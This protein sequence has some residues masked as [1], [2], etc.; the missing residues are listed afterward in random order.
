MVGQSEAREAAGI[1]VHMIKDGRMAGRAILLAGP[2]GTG[3][4]AIALAIAKELGRDVPFV[5][6]SGS[7]IYSTE[8]KKTEV[9]M[10]AMR[11]AIGIRIHELRRVYEGEV[12]AQDIRMTRHP[13][14]PYQQ[15]PE[16]AKITLATKSER[17]TFTVGQSIAMN[18]INQGVTIGDI[19][20]IDAET[21]R[22]TKLGKSKEAEA[23][24]PRYD[25]EVKGVEL[26]RPSGSI[27]K[28]RE[29]VYTMTVNNLDEIQAR[30]AGF[31]SVLFGGG[32][33][34]IDNQVRQRV[35]ETIKT[36]VEEGR[37]EIIPGVLFIDDIHMLDIEAFS[38]LSRALETELAPIVILASNRGVTTIRGTD[39]KSPHGMP[40]DLLDRLLIINTRLYT[41]GEIEEILKI[42]AK[43]EKVELSKEALEYLTKVGEDSSLR[44][45]VQLL[46]P[47][48]EVAKSRGKKQVDVE[49]IE[50]V[51]GLFSD[52]RRSIEH[53]KMY[54]DKMMV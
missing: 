9:L 17:R 42:R 23:E 11:R 47:S 1:I 46:T 20:M 35:D 5:M 39:I 43:E 37:A 29:F 54:E 21:G 52:I 30:S 31:F 28:E 48:A 14:N 51:K 16:N 13:Y 18:L 26:E 8:M 22:V 34:E 6:L 33:A 36:M 2:P 41:H 12:V 45:A 38:F 40:L 49:D 27:Q 19:I 3:K 25:I 15:I 7:E 4:T 50:R 24:I 53:L 10:Q 32:R 44:Y